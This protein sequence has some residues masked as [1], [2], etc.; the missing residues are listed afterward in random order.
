MA[1]ERV[2]FKANLV[3][4]T[5]EAS[6]MMHIPSVDVVISKKALLERKNGVNSFFE[7]YFGAEK[8]ENDEKMCQKVASLDEKTATA[9][10]ESLGE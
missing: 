8:E 3:D 10:L 5:K 2:C 6:D 7:T 4:L 9:L 1:P